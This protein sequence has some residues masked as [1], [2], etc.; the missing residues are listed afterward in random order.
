MKWYQ[1]QCDKDKE[2]I[3]INGVRISTIK[4]LADEL[5]AM[6]DSSYYYHT[7]NRNDFY[8]WVKD[9]FGMEQL[10]KQLLIASNQYE[11]AA[12]IYRYIVEHPTQTTRTRK[13][14]KSTK[15]I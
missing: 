14:K 10:A 2:F 1:K 4:Q 15:N 3:A 11:A 13:R 6:D 12:R 9:V 5:L 7:N 8:N